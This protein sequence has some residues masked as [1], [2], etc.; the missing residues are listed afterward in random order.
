[1]FAE[2]L[3]QQRLDGGALLRGQ[4][5]QGESQIV[6]NRQLGGHARRVREFLEGIGIDKGLERRRWGGVEVERIRQPR[7]GCTG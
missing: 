6:R 4:L 1:M 2:G 3:A 5:G 7:H